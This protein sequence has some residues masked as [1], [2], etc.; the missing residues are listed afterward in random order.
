MLPHEYLD[1]LYHL[2]NQEQEKILESIGQAARKESA[3]TANRVAD[4]I[5]QLRE[6]RRPTLEAIDSEIE[7]MTR[8]CSSRRYRL[9]A[10][11]HAWRGFIWAIAAMMALSFSL[12]APV[13]AQG[14]SGALTGPDI[15]LGIVA[16]FF[17]AWAVWSSVPPEN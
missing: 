6:E 5:S 4:H 12:W 10:A 2:R 3:L 13:N 16:A 17:F 15:F 7:R 1:G 8:Y 9:W 11:S 14:Q